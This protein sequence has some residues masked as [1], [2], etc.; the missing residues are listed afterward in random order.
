LTARCRIVQTRTQELEV[1]GD[2]VCTFR[3]G[4]ASETAPEGCL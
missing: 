4:A 1:I 3:F 2:D